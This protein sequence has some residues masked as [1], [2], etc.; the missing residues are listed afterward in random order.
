MADVLEYKCPCCGAGLVFHEDTQKLTCPFCDNEFTIETIQALKESQKAG[1]DE[2]QWEPEEHENWADPDDVRVF[3]CSSCGG[4]LITDGNTA[5]TFCPFCGNPTILPGRLSGGLKP[6]GVLP[7]Q[8]SKEDAKAAF[9]KL[10]KGK[11]LLPKDFKSQNRL[12]K[13]TGLYVPFWLYDCKGAINASYK[14]TRVHCWSDSKYNYTRTEHFLLQR[15]ADA[16]FDGIP[17]DGSSKMENQYME[18]IEPFDYSKIVPFDTAYL[19]GF[20]A[21][22]YDVEA[23]SGEPRIKDRVSQSLNM[24]LQPSLAGF[25]T[26]I[27]TG[28]TVNVAH[29]K[30]RYVLMPVWMLTTRYKDKTYLFAMNGQS[31]KM[32]GSLPVSKGRSAAWFSAFT[33]LGAIAFWLFF[34]LF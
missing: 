33:A 7:F 5:A 16:Q 11:P 1:K 32:T 30:S 21:D 27:P 31:G 34:Y 13:I 25:S 6:D 22:K 9:L 14:A 8:K 12:E 19:S 15:D 2:F 28:S 24:L 26:L 23:K 18:S 29:S 3:L 10:C 17:M 20:L 4:E